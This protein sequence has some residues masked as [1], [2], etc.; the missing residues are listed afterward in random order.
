MP[1]RPRHD[2]TLR[3]LTFVE[4]PDAPTCE[5]LRQRGALRNTFVLVASV[6]ALCQR[7]LRERPSLFKTFM[8]RLRWDPR[9]VVALRELHASTPTLDFSRDLLEPGQSSLLVLPMPPCGWADL[10]TRA[11]LEAWARDRRRAR[12]MIGIP[13][14]GHSVHIVPILA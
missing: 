5:S 3:V 6:E 13:E 1:G 14:E 11:R 4:K 10:G 12:P 9:D 7:Y 2:G 8:W